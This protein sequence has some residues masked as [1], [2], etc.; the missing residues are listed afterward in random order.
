MVVG[1]GGEEGGGERGKGGGGRAYHEFR[2][3]KVLDFLT[4]YRNS[5]II[6]RIKF[7]RH[8]L[9]VFAVNLARQG[10]NGTRFT[11][12]RGA[13]E[14]EVRELVLGHEAPDCRLSIDKEWSSYMYHGICVVSLDRPYTVS[15]GSVGART[16]I[17]R[18][19]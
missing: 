12:A 11:R 18:A 16:A 19:C 13:V 3:R 2:G 14:H 8:I 17:R 4:N 7:Q 15:R 9:H 5:A 1:R 10:E 6:R